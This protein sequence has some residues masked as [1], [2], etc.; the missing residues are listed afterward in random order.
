MNEPVKFVAAMLEAK[1]TFGELCER[2][3]ISR[4]R[5]YKWKG[6]YEAGGVRARENRS[7]APH[8]RPH[9]VPAEVIQLLDDTSFDGR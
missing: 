9:A 1:E 3:G 4:K 8:S 7:R 5:G 2:F 6:R